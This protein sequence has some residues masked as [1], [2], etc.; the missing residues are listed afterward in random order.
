MY[1]SGDGGGDDHLDNVCLVRGMG[2]FYSISRDE[3][4]MLG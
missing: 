1:L 4:E 3:E 2:D